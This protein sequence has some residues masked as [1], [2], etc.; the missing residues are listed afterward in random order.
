MQLNWTQCTWIGASPTAKGI[1]KASLTQAIETPSF[2]K[3]N[4]MWDCLTRCLR[5]LEKA[6]EERK[7]AK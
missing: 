1:V 5:D 4:E 6:I 7:S 3:C 2:A